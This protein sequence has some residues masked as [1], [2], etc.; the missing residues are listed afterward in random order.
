MRRRPRPRPALTPS[1]PIPRFPRILAAPTA[2]PTESKAA[3]SSETP[4][5]P[6][7]PP[8]SNDPPAETK[9]DPAAAASPA[10]SAKDAEPAPVPASETTKPAAEPTPA[11]AEET[12]PKPAAASPFASGDDGA[13]AAVAPARRP[14]W[15]EVASSAPSLPPVADVRAPISRRRAATAAETELARP[16]E[17]GPEIVRAICNYDVRKT[18]LLDFELPDVTGRPVRFQDLDA[19]F[20]LL[21]F[22]GT[23]C[24][25]CLNTVPHLIALQKQFGPERLKVVGIAYENAPA[26]EAAA[27]VVTTARRLGI[28]YTVLLGGLDGKPCPLQAAFHVQSYPTLVLLDRHGRVLWRRPRRQ[29]VHAGTPR[30]RPDRAGQDGRGAKIARSAAEAAAQ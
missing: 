11:P 13:Q 7:L 20:I 2:E 29:P 18:Q 4:E 17:R 12:V 30:S 10:P 3:E 15:G 27:R 22:W 23:W 21:D 25:P 16:A 28:N 24:G 14:T 6:V 5:T 1:A 26:A 8:L 9:P 19:D